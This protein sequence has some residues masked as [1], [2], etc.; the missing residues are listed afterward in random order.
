MQK[1]ICVVT[2][3][4][5]DFGILS[6]LIK[7]LNKSNKI[8]LETVVSGS[9]LAKSYGSTIDEIIE[10]DIKITK[11]IN[12]LDDK[13]NNFSVNIFTKSII[14]F[15]NFFKKKKIDIVL[16]L[17][18]RY[19]L[20]AI[21]SVCLLLNIPI[22][23][24]HGGEV[25]EGAIDDVI[26]H[27][28]TKMS[29]F[30]FTSTEKYRQRV[31]QLGENPKNVFNVGS[32]GVQNLKKIKKISK[33][34]LETKLNIKF[35]KSNLFLTYHPE[36][37]SNV[38]SETILE[39]IFKVV[40][41]YKNIN[42]FIS[43]PNFDDKAFQIVKSIKKFS[44]KNKNCFLFKSLG[45]EKYFSLISYMDGVIGNSSSGIIEVPSL[46]V[47]TVNIG[48]RQKGRI[49]P[50]SVINCQNNYTSIKNGIKKLF[51]KK[52]KNDLK[53]VKNPYEGKNT[54]KKITRILE[55]VRIPDKPIKRFHDL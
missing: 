22:A 34:D 9:H 51:S 13:Y 39:Y 44:K 49:I 33:L 7:S 25:T 53:N 11:K 5:S 2:T 52:F 40:S 38:K 55:Q 15:G 41:E 47:G 31:I 32:L 46:K 14:K 18:D 20:L 24:L 8:I 35:N 10:S 37:L 4:R 50:R 48:N 30:H 27:S 45:K 43:L 36:T 6:D 23:H 42:L 12:I 16:L 26:R 1:K 29:F 54:V 21:S 19:E 28:I 17:G 3:S